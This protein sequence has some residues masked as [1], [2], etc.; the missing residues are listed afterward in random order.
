MSTPTQTRA[1]TKTASH[2]LGHGQGNG[3][4]P[5]DFHE[6][7]PGRIAPAEKKGLK[8]RWLLTDITDINPDEADVDQS[9][10]ARPSKLEGRCL[11]RLTSVPCSCSFEYP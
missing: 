8:E 2:G 6:T 3:H 5:M 10:G 9:A 4:G 7:A 1:F 11:F